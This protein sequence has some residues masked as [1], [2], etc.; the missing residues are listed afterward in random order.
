MLLCLQA[1]DHISQQ[2]GAALVYAAG[3]SLGSM[4]L[5]KAL[6]EPGG[7]HSSRHKLGRE[8]IELLHALCQAAWR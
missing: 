1:V 3:Y 8:S 6:T 2:H 7:Q 4:I 5:A